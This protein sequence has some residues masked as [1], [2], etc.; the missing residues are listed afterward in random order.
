MASRFAPA[1]FPDSFPD[2][3]AMNSFC[4][5]H[6][7]RMSSGVGRGSGYLMIDWEDNEAC[8]TQTTYNGPFV[9]SELEYW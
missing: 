9:K 1:E 8:Y 2:V 6:L 3:E 7:K 4:E 5:A